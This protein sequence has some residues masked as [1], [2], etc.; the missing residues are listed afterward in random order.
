MFRNLTVVVSSVFLLALAGCAG[1]EPDDAGADPASPKATS[2]AP[3]TTSSPD[4][5]DASAVDQCELLTDA[6][7]AELAGEPL[8]GKQPHTIAGQLP[9]CVWGT[10]EKHVQVG[11]VSA[12]DWARGLPTIVEQLK[13]GGAVDAANFQKLEDA[14]DLIASGESI[15][16]DQACGL[17]TKLVELNG[18]PKG[19]NMTVN[20]VP[21][22]ND[23]QAITGQACLGGNYT[24]VLLVRPGLS[25]SEEENQRVE[26]ALHQA[27]GHNQN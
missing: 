16:A 7:I 20:L 9:A 25:G 3:A 19:S 12:V 27:M 6:Q 15:P 17:F 11:S 4:T 22:A 10:P 23:P 8:A 1:D 13:A 14:A 2:S 5:S 21:D 26:Q 18:L 24:T